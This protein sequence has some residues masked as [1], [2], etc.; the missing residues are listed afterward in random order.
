MMTTRSRLQPYASLYGP[1]AV[2][3]LALSFTPL[4]HLS[5]S[6]TTYSLWRESVEPGGEIAMI[7][8]IALLILVALLV[9][10]VFR[11]DIPGLGFP[12]AVLAALIAVMLAT[13]P[14]FGEE[15]TLSYFGVACIVVACCGAA[16][17]TA[18]GVHSI[19]IRTLDQAA[20]TGQRAF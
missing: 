6:S 1:L 9:V 3:A 13:H 16:L 10:A 12:I 17:G 7:G 20:P 14:G 19:V 15:V 11:P 18:H 8:V 5:E 4:L 2:V